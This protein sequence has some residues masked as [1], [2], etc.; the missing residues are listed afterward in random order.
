MYIYLL[1]NTTHTYLVCTNTKS[2]AVAKGQNLKG[3]CCSAA[4]VV[5][6]SVYRGCAVAFEIPSKCGFMSS[7]PFAASNEMRVS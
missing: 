1:V 7:C 3:W 6:F 2:P 4:A 5:V